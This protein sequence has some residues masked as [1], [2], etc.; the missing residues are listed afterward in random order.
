MEDEFLVHL[1]LLLH[2]RAPIA[3]EAFLRP[4]RKSRP[5]KARDAFVAQLEQMLG[6]GFGGGEVVGF[7]IWKV[8]AKQRAMPE[9]DGGHF[10]F[11]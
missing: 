2:Q 5:G 6:G 11:F 4:R 1:N 9:D 10:V 3:F 8:T 7:H